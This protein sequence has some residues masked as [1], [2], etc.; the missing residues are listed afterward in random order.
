M[1][2]DTGENRSILEGGVW[3]LEGRAASFNRKRE[4][5]YSINSK[6]P[7]RYLSRKAIYI[8]EFLHPYEY[9]DEFMIPT[10]SY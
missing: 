10:L 2:I 7:T 9:N 3:Q 5:A 8:F 1:G 6:K 4:Y